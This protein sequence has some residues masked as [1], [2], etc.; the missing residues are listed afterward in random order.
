M[1]SGQWYMFSSTWR[2]HFTNRGRYMFYEILSTQDSL[3]SGHCAYH[4]QRK[5]QLA[6][7][8]NC[9]SSSFLQIFYHL[10]FSESP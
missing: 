6:N 10:F 9:F 8:L 4:M 5:H 7:W 2:G 1:T 3:L